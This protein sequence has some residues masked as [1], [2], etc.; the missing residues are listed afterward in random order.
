VRTV[1]WPATFKMRMDVPGVLLHG[2][3]VSAGLAAKT[4]AL[5]LAHGPK[6]AREDTHED[7]HVAHVLATIVLAAA[8]IEA[9][10]NEVYEDVANAASVI[11]KTIGPR[12]KSPGAADRLSVYW[13]A[14]QS[15][16][17]VDTLE[18]YQ[19]ALRFIGEER[20]DTGTHPY[21][22]AALVLQLRN[23]CMHYKAAWSDVYPEG[24]TAWESALRGRFELN[25]WVESWDIPSPFFPQRVLGAGCAQWALRSA[26]DFVT[27]FLDRL[28]SV[29]NES[30]MWKRSE[31]TD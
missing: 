6:D 31:P 2:C 12:L 17:R 16:R 7:T 1:E 25:Q 27:A 28:S 10:I 24:P 9:A 20:F 14:T 26:E 13:E 30:P 19:A 21:Q 8:Y 4:E 3:R 15:G 23:W 5:L 18:K 11:E 22:D 29:E